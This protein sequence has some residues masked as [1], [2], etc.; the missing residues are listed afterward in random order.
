MKGIPVLRCIAG[1]S[2]GRQFELVATETVVGRGEEAGIKIATG[3]RTLSRR[4]ILIKNKE[5]RFVLYN[6]SNNGTLLNNLP[7]E[8]AVLHHG[9]RIEIGDSELEFVL[10][11]EGAAEIKPAATEKTIVEKPGGTLEKRSTETLSQPSEGKP[12]ESTEAIA[13]SADPKK[14]SKPL[15]WILL[16]GLLIVILY[17]LFFWSSEKGAAI[18]P[19]KPIE[20]KLELTRSLAPDQALQLAREKMTHAEKLY[21]DRNLNPRNSSEA[22]TAFYQCRE[23]LKMTGS[24]P[25][26]FSGVGQRIY[27]IEQLINKD[28]QNW[29]QRVLLAERQKDVKTL[30]FCLENIMT[31]IPDQ[32]DP[33][34]AWAK[35]I[36]NQ[37]NSKT[38]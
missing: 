6:Q 12:R 11:D 13:A 15:K 25:P 37:K 3:N 24:L 2:K 19:P 36:F 18:I 33:R 8:E 10:T 31:L 17:L 34:H 1:L 32:H 28:Y 35:K 30:R 23:Y 4:H 9:D 38:L 16:L 20:K 21:Q 22:L 29:Q 5:G 7:V 26:E 14:S 27:E